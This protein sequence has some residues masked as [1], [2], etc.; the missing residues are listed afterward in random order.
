MYVLTNDTTL[1]YVYKEGVLTVK[2]YVSEG[3]K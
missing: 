1:M 2:K 3:K